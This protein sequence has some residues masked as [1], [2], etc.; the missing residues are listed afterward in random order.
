MVE[1]TDNTG[2]YMTKSFNLPNLLGLL[3]LFGS[4]SA[5]GFNTQFLEGAPIE[6]MSEV[7]I[8]NMISGFYSALDNE[9]ENGSFKW[10]GE[11]AEVGGTIEVAPRV[12]K[13]DSICRKAHYTN[14]AGGK[15]AS[16]KLNFCQAADGSWQVSH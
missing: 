10:L 5:S 9:V 8:E 6:Y 2:S 1:L 15:V 7:D 14:R 16:G 11:S 4:T 13:N 3:M 12:Q